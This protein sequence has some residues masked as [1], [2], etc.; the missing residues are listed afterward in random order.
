MYLGEYGTYLKGPLDSLARWTAFVARVAED[1]GMS[2]SYY[3]HA[4]GFG[5]CDPDTKEWIKPLLTALVRKS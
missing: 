3:D 2:G 4:S 5:V 1:D